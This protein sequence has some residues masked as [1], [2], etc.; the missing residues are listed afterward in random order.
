MTQ[1]FLVPIY[2]FLFTVLFRSLNDIMLESLSIAFAFHVVNLNGLLFR[3]IILCFL[4][5]FSSVLSRMNQISLFKRKVSASEKVLR[6]NVD[7]KN[8]DL[9]LL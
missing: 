5:Y 1:Y 9:S 7:K 6:A 8:A 4:I 3:Q 2:L